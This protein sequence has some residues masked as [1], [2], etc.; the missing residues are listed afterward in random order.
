MIN[1]VQLLPLP[2]QQ[3][4]K[5]DTNGRGRIA[6]TNTLLA[7]QILSTQ[8]KSQ[9]AFRHHWNT[10]LIHRGVSLSMYHCNFMPLALTGPSCG[11]ASL[12]LFITGHSSYPE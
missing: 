10:T 4:R 7:F 6:A 3:C 1:A 11:T 5:N 9:R 2:S 12:H 8:P